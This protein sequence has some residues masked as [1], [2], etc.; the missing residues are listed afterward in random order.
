MAADHMG[1]RSHLRASFKYINRGLML[2][3]IGLGGGPLLANPL[4]GYVVELR[5]TGR[6]S[7][8]VRS[9]PVN[10]AIIDGHLYCLAGWGRSTHWFAN[11]RANP[12]VELRLPGSTIIGLAEEVTDPAEAHR[13]IVQVTRNAGIGLLFEGINP[14]TASDA[15][16]LAR[17]GWMPVIRIRP[18]SFAPGPLDPGGRAWLLPALVFALWLLRRGRA[19]SRR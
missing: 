10:Y 2:P 8:Q 5:T 13:A 12:R 9:A 1:W 3:L 18:T 16:L 14:L 19:G 6:R 11:L 4:V 15:N 17:N 7:G